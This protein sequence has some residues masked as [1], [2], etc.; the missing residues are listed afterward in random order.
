VELKNIVDTG[1]PTGP[2]WRHVRPPAPV[3]VDLA[4][5]HPLPPHHQSAPISGGLALRRTVTGRLSIWGRSFEGDWW[6][7]VSYPTTPTTTPTADELPA[8]TVSHWVPGHLL[9]PTG[10]TTTGHT[11]PF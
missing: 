1:K 9:R 5:M 2:G 11:P 7:F 10:V 4:A 3:E 8:G 6:G